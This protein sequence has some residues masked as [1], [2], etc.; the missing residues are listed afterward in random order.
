MYMTKRHQTLWIVLKL[1]FCRG[2]S[3]ISQRNGT[4]SFKASTDRVS[5]SW[6]SLEE[7]ISAQI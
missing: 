3:H 5:Q 7:N 1:K 6:K 2:M 4:V